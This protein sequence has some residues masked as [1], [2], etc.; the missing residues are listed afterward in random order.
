MVKTNTKYRVLLASDHFNS[1]PGWCLESPA[2][3]LPT[4]ARD[5]QS[6]YVCVRQPER[7]LDKGGQWVFEETVR[8]IYK[9]RLVSEQRT[10]TSESARYLEAQRTATSDV[11]SEHS[12]FVNVIQAARSDQVSHWGVEPG[13]APGTAKFKLLSDHNGQDHGWY[14]EA[15]NVSG[16]DAR[17][18][19]STYVNVHQPD[20]DANYAGDWLLEELGLEVEPPRATVFDDGA[21]FFGDEGAE[22]ASD[23]CASLISKLLLDVPPPCEVVRASIADALDLS[24]S[25]NVA[26]VRGYVLG[27]YLVHEL[28]RFNLL[29]QV[30]RDFLTRL[31]D[32]LSGMSRMSEDLEAGWS[33]LREGVVPLSWQAVAYPCCKPLVGWVS[34]LRE[35]FHFLQEWQR[36][37]EPPLCFWISYFFFP[38]GFLTSV[39]QSYARTHGTPIDILEMR[40]VVK[41]TF[42]DPSAINVGPEDGVYT[43]GPFLD[44]GR[45]DIHSQLVEDCRPAEMFSRMPVI[46]FIPV[47]IDEKALSQTVERRGSR[48]SSMLSDLVDLLAGDVSG[49]TYTCPLYKTASRLGELSTTGQ[50][51]NLIST[52]QLPTTEPELWI[53]RGVALVC[54]PD[55]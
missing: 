5:G 29:L 15:H 38:Q 49:T 54:E 46:Q 42:N 13:S 19:T 27:V 50:S 35:R 20:D 37:E 2:R 14:L 30:V 32:A 6:S 18:E 11:R 43:F 53:L 23:S 3:A 55:I 17:D 51:T 34:D 8:G 1:C 21:A 7:D 36:A 47:K 40:Q 44:G 25:T 31:S 39:L 24:V 22:S 41:S 26:L 52:V 4:D 16:R 10:A 45:W 48:R 28:E 12:T 9:I 33:A